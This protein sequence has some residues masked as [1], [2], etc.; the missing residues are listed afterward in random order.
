MAS[1][2]F[3]ASKNFEP[4]FLNHAHRGHADQGFVFDD[5]DHLS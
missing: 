3:A 5:E 2:A 1:S 4:G